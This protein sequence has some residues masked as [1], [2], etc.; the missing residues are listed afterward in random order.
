MLYSFPLHASAVSRLSRLF[1]KLG[2][3]GLSVMIDHTD[4]LPYLSSL[5]AMSHLAPLVFL[6]LDR[7]DHRAGVI[8]RTPMY[9]A[10]VTALLREELA[11]ICVLHGVYTHGSGSYRVRSTE[12]AQASILTEA[13]ALEEAAD[14]IAQLIPKR[15]LTLSF[16][17][18]PTALGLQ[19]VTSANEHD[20]GNAVSGTPAEASPLVA[21]FSRWRAKGFTAEVHAGVYTT[22][23]IQQLATRASPLATTDDIAITVLAE[24]A[25][26]YSRRGPGGEAEA[27]ITAG[28]LSLAREPCGGLADERPG[29]GPRYT[30]WGILA[31]WRVANPL[32]GPEFPSV[33]EG[34]QVARISQE[35][36][37]LQWTGPLGRESELN[38]GQRVRVWPNHSC[39][40]GACFDY[41][42][43]VDS[44]AANPDLIVDVWPR[45]RAW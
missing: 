33:Y 26:K 39:I 45:C 32:P 21:L 35:H 11:G 29:R 7:G 22:M 9:H 34:W 12:A 10:V 43:V 15:N 4:Q 19:G 3:G 25:S 37:V 23:D 24:V 2:K 30:G 41:Y 18:S 1:T 36:G 42:V 27:V 13:T 6:K 16:G 40:A 17:A 44:R 38:I 8:F 5:A 20:Q 31:P 14:H 28:S